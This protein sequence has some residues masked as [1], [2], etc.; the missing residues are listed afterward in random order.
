M[1]FTQLEYFV[2]VAREQHFGRAAAASFVS[3]SALSESI[4]KLEAEL[5]VPLVRRGRS[6]QGLTPEGEAV[7]VWA[8]RMI[9]DHRALKDEVSSAAARLNGVVRVGVIPSGVALAARVLA[10]LC[11]THPDLQVRLVTGLTS[12]QVVGGLRSFEF[13]AGLLHPSAAAADDIRH[14]LV[15]TDRLVVVGAASRSDFGETIE[16]AALE[17][18]PVCVLE[19]SMRARQILD[20]ALS[21]R[22]VRL[23]PRVEVDSVEALLALARTGEWVSVVPRSAVPKAAASIGVKVAEIVRPEVSIPIVLAML[24]E[25]PRPPLSLAVD[26]AARRLVT[27]PA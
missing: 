25:E 15:E 17:G 27:P 19:P 20:D 3:A 18:L 12:E 23:R 8:R 9:A 21:E 2:A 24:G 7:L 11:A 6:F 16:L 14:I 22:G 26:A 5:G 4:R 1:L 10:E 13:D